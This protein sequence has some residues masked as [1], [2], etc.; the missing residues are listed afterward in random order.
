MIHHRM[1]W[2]VEL[3]L[4]ALVLILFSSIARGALN[5]VMVP[6]SLSPETPL[7]VNA[8]KEMPIPFEGFDE[9]DK[10][11]PADIALINPL[12]GQEITSRHTFM[13]MV[14]VRGL[15]VV[16][17]IIEYP[18]GIHSQ[19]FSA[20]HMGKSVWKLELKGFTQGRWHWWVVARNISHSSGFGV[21]SPVTA[22]VVKHGEPA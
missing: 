9:Q 13:A 6:I 2:V 11:S 18:N 21:R 19:T 8:N 12:Q 15:A 22:F 20:L 17:F 10:N 1:Y 7:S 4:F 14:S 16:S 5:A 3:T